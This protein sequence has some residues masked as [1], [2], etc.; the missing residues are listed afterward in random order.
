MQKKQDDDKAKE[1][2][3]KTIQTGFEGKHE[4]ANSNMKFYKKSTMVAEFK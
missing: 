3:A 1:L 2:L 4:V